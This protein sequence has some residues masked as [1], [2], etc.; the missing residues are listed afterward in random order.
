MAYPVT[1]TTAE[2]WRFHFI[3]IFFVIYI[4]VWYFFIAAI[5]NDMTV[6]LRDG[7]DDILYLASY[8]F[9]W[10]ALCMSHEYFDVG[11][12]LAIDVDSYEMLFFWKIW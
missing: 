2:L 3:D 5:C 11:M 9:I 6:R 8:E 1:K 10:I 7:V 4:Q 12:G